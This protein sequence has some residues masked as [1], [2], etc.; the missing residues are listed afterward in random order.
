MVDIY[1]A[2]CSSCKAFFEV[3][4][5]SENRDIVYEIYSCPAC[6][7]LFSIANIEKDL[8]CPK[9]GNKNLRRYNMHKEGNVRYYRKML[10]KGL[11]TQEKYNILINYWKDIL[12]NTC[13]KCGRD[14]LTWRLY[15]K[16][17]NI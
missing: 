17:K 12:S 3:E 1:R 9:C 8:S 16:A 14:M 13:P 5:G 6:K 11:L 10:Q 7:N 15:E 4:Y 2:S